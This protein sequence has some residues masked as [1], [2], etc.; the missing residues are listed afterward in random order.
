MVRLNKV[1]PNNRAKPHKLADSMP[2]TIPRHT[3]LGS[4]NPSTHRSWVKQSFDTQ[5]SGQTIPRHTGLGSKQLLDTQVSDEQL[6][7]TQVLDGVYHREYATTAPG[8]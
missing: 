2:T 1:I 5:V 6:L 8:K 3:G 4:N 7:D